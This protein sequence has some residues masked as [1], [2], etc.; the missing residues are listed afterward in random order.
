MIALRKFGFFFKSSVFQWSFNTD[1]EGPSA[2][3][4]GISNKFEEFG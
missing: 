3:F 2:D 4:L 1:N